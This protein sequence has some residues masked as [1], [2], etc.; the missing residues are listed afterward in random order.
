MKIDI[1]FCVAWL[2]EGERISKD[3]REKLSLAHLHGTAWQVRLAEGRSSKASCPELKQAFIY[4]SYREIKIHL[5][6]H[7]QFLKSIKHFDAY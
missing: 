1:G 2:E 3:A 5:F 4:S 6:C 7:I